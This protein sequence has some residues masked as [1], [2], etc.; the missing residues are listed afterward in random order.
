MHPLTASF[1]AR[2]DRQLRLSTPLICALILFLVFILPSAQGS[3]WLIKGALLVTLAGVWAWAPRRYEVGGDGLIIRRWIGSVRIPLSGLKS[4]R[5]MSPGE[6]RGA[7]RTW[8]VGCCFGYYGRFLN[9]LESQRWYVT[10]RRSCVRLDCTAEVVVISPSN[11]AACLSA[12][13][14]IVLGSKG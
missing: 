11:P 12:L 13:D 3:V 4:A 6:L 8:A 1:A 7:T 2:W 9:G 5:F 14:R 10:D